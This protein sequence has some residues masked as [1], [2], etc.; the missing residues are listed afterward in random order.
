MHNLETQAGFAERDKDAAV[1]ALAALRKENDTLTLQQSH[2]DDLRRT[3]EQLEHLAAL[4]TQQTAQSNEPELKD[5]RR[6]RDRLESE[7]S[8]LQRRYKEQETRVA[9]S[10]R[11]AS[12]ARAS[13]AQAQLR[14]KEWEERAAE[15]EEA[16]VEAQAVRDQAED[17]AA[18]MEA[19]H[20][21]VRMQLEEKD[22]EERLTK[23]RVCCSLSRGFS[24]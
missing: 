9:N 15:N 24:F 18:Q 3:N 12:T 16:L 6:A 2:W 21:L 17:R 8:A 23:V 5:L 14:A 20:A 13:L 7:Y 1:D 22:A 19:E 4:V 10:D 11:A